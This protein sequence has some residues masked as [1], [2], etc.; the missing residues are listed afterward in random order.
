MKHTL[1]VTVL[2]L[3]LAGSTQSAVA[4]PTAL[5]LIKEGNKHVGEQAKDKIVQIRSERSVGSLTP[6]VWYIVYYDPTATL[7]ATEVKFGAG[8]MMKVTRPLRLLEPVTG[9]D[10]QLDSTKIKIDS[11]KA[12]AVA[13]REPL[14]SGL[15]LKA[16][17]LWLTRGDTRIS[18]D[19][20]GPVWR[21]KFFA[22][23]NSN[24]NETADIGDIL[25]AADTGNVV[26]SDL[27]INS[28]E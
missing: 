10:K 15:E 11:D 24:K 25:I 17:Q 18:S 22:A 13:Q 26:K 20:N 1:S 23:K 14:L 6:R 12:L 9:E 16:S 5:E 27:H 2:A 19:Y 21:V 7:K 4:D 3:M 28:A 8:K